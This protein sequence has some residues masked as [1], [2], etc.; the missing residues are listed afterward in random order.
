MINLFKTKMV[1]D[2]INDQPEKTQEI[3]N[4]SEYCICITNSQGNFVYV[5]DNYCQNYE[6]DRSEL[7]GNHFSMVVVDGE[8]DTMTNLHDKFIET[9]REI[10]RI[11]KVKTKTGRVLNINV[12]AR[13]TD[14]INNEP[15]KI[16]FVEVKP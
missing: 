8:E 1:R 10:S 14:Q 5:N 2:S 13:F 15:H 9:Q 16:T 3:I 12:D 4:E 6:Y 7:I 11:W